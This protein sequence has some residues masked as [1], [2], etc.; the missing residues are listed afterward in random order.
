MIKN[1]LLSILCVALFL[2]ILEVQQRI[3][4][5]II[6]KD[7]YYLSYGSNNIQNIIFEWRAK[8]KQT[9]KDRRN[10]IIIDCYGGST[11]RGGADGLVKLQDCYPAVMEKILDNK[12]PDLNIYVNNYGHPGND[13]RDNLL[14]IERNYCQLSQIPDVIILYIGI[15]D[16]LKDIG[17]LRFRQEGDFYVRNKDLLPFFSIED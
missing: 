10:K 15:N 16:Y 11:T 7:I 14:S 9:K 3:R 4:Y 13:S 6:H 17:I 2:G 12:Y 1:I 5:A 8:N